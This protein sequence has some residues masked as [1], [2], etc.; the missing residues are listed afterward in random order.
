M[1]MWTWVA[2]I[3]FL[4]AFFVTHHLSKTEHNPPIGAYIAVMGLVAACVTF[5][6]EPSRI[7]KAL[8]IGV[9]T[10][11]M[12]AEI[13]NL[14]V[15]DANQAA[16]FGAISNALATTASSLQSTAADMK[17]SLAQTTGGDSYIYS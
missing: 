7:E 17:E 13:K 16:T 1:R 15:A 11:L 8:W 14:Y 12:F 10:I 9:M 3:S 4:L 6:K 5:R 2:F